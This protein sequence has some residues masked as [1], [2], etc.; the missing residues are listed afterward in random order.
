MMQKYNVSMLVYKNSLSVI[1]SW[2]N[3]VYTSETIVKDT[4]IQLI[5]HV[6]CRFTQANI[7]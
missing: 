6:D 1:L 5:L 2:G 7:Q 4:Q 3:N